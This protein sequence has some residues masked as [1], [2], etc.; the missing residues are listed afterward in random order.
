MVYRL[1]NKIKLKMISTFNRYQLML[2]CWKHNPDER[3]TFAQLILTLE[4]MMTADT[5]YYDF[6]NLDETQPCYGNT[7]A[8]ISE[9]EELDTKM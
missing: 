2:D 1:N 3:P 4:R 9:T 8:S 7:A 6:S 5:P